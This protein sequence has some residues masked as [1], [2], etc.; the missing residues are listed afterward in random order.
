MASGRKTTTFED[1]TAV[2]VLST[3]K[4]SAWFHDDWCIGS[5]LDILSEYT[6]PN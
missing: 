2:K 4:Y 1:A 6:Y 3:H 5:G